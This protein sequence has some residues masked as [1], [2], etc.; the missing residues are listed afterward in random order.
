MTKTDEAPDRPLGSAETE[1]R[2]PEVPGP[3]PMTATDVFGAT[4]VGDADIGGVATVSTPQADGAAASMSKHNLIGEMIG[5]YEVDGVVGQGG[6]GVV[7]SGVHPLI[8]KKVAIKIL[9]PEL[10]GDQEAMSRFLAEAKAVNAIGHENIIDIFSFGS[11]EDDAQYFVMEYLQGLSLRDYLKEHGTVP[12]PVAFSVV[13]QVLQ[14]LKAAHAKG[15]IHRDLKPD[16]I[17][18]VER[19][20]G[21]YFVKLLD[22][23]IAKFA[24]AG[25]KTAQ[26][27]TGTPLGTPYY[28]GPEQCAGKGVDHQ[29]DIYSLGIILYEMF[30]GRLPFKGNSIAAIITAHLTETPHPPSMLADLPEDLETIILWCLEKEKEQRPQDAQQLMS[31]LLPTLKKLGDDAP[32]VIDGAEIPEAME[33]SLSS[34]RGYQSAAGRSGAESGMSATA[35]IALSAVLVVLLGMGGFFVYRGVFGGSGEGK[36]AGQSQQPGPA[37]VKND[38]GKSGTSAMIGATDPMGIGKAT[39]TKPSGQPEPM[40]LGKV[41][42]QL[43]VD[44]ADV[45]HEVFVDGVRH[46]KNFFKVVRNENKSILIEVKAKGYQRWQR[47]VIPAFSQNI[48]VNLKKRETR[49]RI[50]RPGMRRRRRPSMAMSDDI[51]SV[52]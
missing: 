18:L 49:R 40:T 15:I 11:L 13:S 30:T 8:G 16:N 10:S 33:F 31:A 7:L 42:L 44:P 41:V 37:S 5:E 25:F 38:A 34:L 21:E 24:E 22:F 4:D 43:Q 26:T 35:K 23:G 45:S 19:P 17:F 39:V 36:T 27:K 2:F 20:G 1:R 3:A 50:I 48:T 12:Y 14:A 28:M 47:K 29:S 9:R 6:M 51:T 46:K 32:Q 52:L